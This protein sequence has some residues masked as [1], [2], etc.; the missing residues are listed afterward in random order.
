MSRRSVAKIR[1]LVRNGYALMALVM[2]VFIG[3]SRTVSRKMGPVAGWELSG[4]W[5]E[6]SEFDLG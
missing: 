6:G 1:T 5:R 4:Y 2:A 3:I